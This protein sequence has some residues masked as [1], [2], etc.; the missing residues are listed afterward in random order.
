MYYNY[1]RLRGLIREHC[2]T[3][4][5]FADKIGISTVSLSQRLNGKLQFTQKEM[6][7]AM[8]IF[9]LNNDSIPSIFFESSVRKTVI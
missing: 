1:Q 9:G 8:P 2:G 6:E 3:Q 7:Y 5:K 4:Q